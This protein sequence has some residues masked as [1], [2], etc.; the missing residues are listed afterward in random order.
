MSRKYF[1]KNGFTM[2][3]VL[4]GMIL[5]AVG[6]LL[7]MPLMVVSMQGNAVARGSTDS[8]MLIRDK[9]E[10]LKNT[11][12]PA[13]GTDT[14]GASI[15]TWTVTDVGTKLRKLQVRINWTDPDGQTRVNSMITYM[16]LE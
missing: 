16:M 3:E 9:I 4:A 13:S 11:S 8:S 12:N 2:V 14:T 5:L 10:E 1:N 15:R 7:L 6:I